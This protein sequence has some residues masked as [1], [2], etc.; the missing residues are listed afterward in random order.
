MIEDPHGSDDWS[1]LEWVGVLVAAAGLAA[2]VIAALAA[3]G[4]GVAI[5]ASLF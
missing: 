2:L 1:T 4:F 5:L 3:A